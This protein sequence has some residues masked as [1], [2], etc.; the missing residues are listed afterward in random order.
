M[1]HFSPNA[2]CALL[3]THYFSVSAARCLSIKTMVNRLSLMMLWS[4][5]WSL[6]NNQLLLVSIPWVFIRDAPIS[7]FGGRS[8]HR[9]HKS[10]GYHLLEFRRCMFCKQ[11]VSETVKK[12]QTGEFILPASFM[13]AEKLSHIVYVTHIY[14]YICDGLFWSTLWEPTDQPV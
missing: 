11:R 13:R 12:F 9:N 5:V 8:D 4:S 7:I 10:A 3:N 14:I 2:F 6:L 1:L